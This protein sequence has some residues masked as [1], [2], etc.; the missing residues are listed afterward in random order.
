MSK[1]YDSP[2]TTAG[3]PRQRVMVYGT[4]TERFWAHIQKTEGCWL[5]TGS[6][7]PYGYGNFS[8]GH[9]RYVGAH[10]FAWEQE[11][12]PVPPGME[13]CHECDVP[14]CVRHLFLGTHTENM[15]DMAAKGRWRNQTAGITHCAQGHEF[16]PENTAMRPNGRHRRCVT[17]M[18]R[19][20]RE[21]A[22]RRRAREKNA[23]QQQESA[24]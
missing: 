13:V 19:C 7:T 22:A 3:K 20:A 5:W 24:A 4:A 6:T 12:G 10:V 14:R 17:C 1:I 23:R 9:R 21:T 2:V 15:R 16:T 8:L 18:R 11:H